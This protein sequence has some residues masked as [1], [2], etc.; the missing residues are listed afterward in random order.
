MKLFISF[1][2]GAVVMGMLAAFLGNNPSKPTKHVAAPI[3]SKLHLQMVTTN[4]FELLLP[5]TIQQEAQLV[6]SGG[7]LDIKSLGFKVVE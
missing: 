6:N 2:A 3:Y 4:G 7:R 5:L 1:C